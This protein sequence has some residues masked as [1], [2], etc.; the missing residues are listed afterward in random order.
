MC[1]HV[2]ESPASRIGKG[3]HGTRLVQ[4]HL[5]DLFFGDLHAAPPEALEVGQAGVG[6]NGHA[7]LE[8]QTDGGGDRAR[9]AC[10]KPTGNVR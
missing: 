7:M 10:M 9:V 1:F 3:P 2:M 5:I 4:R 6:A 8:G